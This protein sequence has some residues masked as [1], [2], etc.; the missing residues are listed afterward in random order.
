MVGK[1]FVVYHHGSE[2]SHRVFLCPIALLTE[3]YS[4]KSVQ[5]N[6]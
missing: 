2:A 6:S 3:S 1:Y 5:Y 4:V